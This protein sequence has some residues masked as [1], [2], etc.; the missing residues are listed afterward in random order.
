MGSP[1]S[2]GSQRVTVSRFYNPRSRR[3]EGCDSFECEVILFTVSVGPLTV[4]TLVVESVHQAEGDR[5]QAMD[6]ARNAARPRRA[7]RIGLQNAP[8]SNARRT[9]NQS[10]AIP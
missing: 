5:V 6:P 9:H 1:S 4:T 7:D 8:P 3:P 2:L 10:D